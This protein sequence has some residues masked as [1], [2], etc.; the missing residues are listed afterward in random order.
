M[1]ALRRTLLGVGRSHH[2]TAHF[3]PLLLPWPVPLSA[4]DLIAEC[5]FWDPG[6]LSN[7]SKE[8]VQL[9]SSTQ[10]VASSGGRKL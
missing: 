5:R 1:P 8:Y 3:S 7:H 6:V 2:F 10:L 9:K 4:F